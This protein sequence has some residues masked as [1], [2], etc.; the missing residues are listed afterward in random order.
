[1]TDEERMIADVLVGKTEAFRE[2]VERYQ[3]P[4]FRMISNLVGDRH[5]AEDIAQEVFITVYRK[6][7]RGWTRKGSIRTAQVD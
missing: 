5:A 4:V 7:Y 3:H 1:M 2:I 6:V